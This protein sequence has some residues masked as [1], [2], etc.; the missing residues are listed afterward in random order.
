M[1]R[2]R[3]LRCCWRKGWWGIP[4]R[5]SSGHQIPG[6]AITAI[7]KRWWNFLP[8]SL[9]LC[10][11]LLGGCER[12]PA[13][14]A[15]PAAPTQPPKS[16]AAAQVERLL[17]AGRIRE[18]D[19]LVDE[20]APGQ[21]TPN[22]EFLRMAARV[23]LNAGHPAAALS[24]AE[25]A[26]ALQPR[27]TETKVVL[28]VALVRTGQAA[29]GEK[30]LSEMAGRF[31]RELN[32]Q[33]QLAEARVLAGKLPE[34]ERAA[35]EAVKLSPDDVGSAPAVAK[36][37]QTLGIVLIAQHRDPEA[38][39][40]LRAAIGFYP[41]SAG[42]HYSLSIALARAGKLDEARAAAAQA[43][44]LDPNNAEF[45][46]N[47]GTILLEQKQWTTAGAS[48][49]KAVALETGDARAW[50]ALGRALLQQKRAPEAAA[51]LEKAVQLDPTQKSA[52]SAL[53]SAAR[54]SGKSARAKEAEEK[55][56]SLPPE[57]AEP[58]KFLN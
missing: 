4:N 23:K 14:P 44:A 50:G 10:G 52:W 47:L 1:G 25:Q 5:S 55:A 27:D 24:F 9:V 54:L 20:Y 38:I 31:S 12:E 30:L 34:A 26:L 7:A 40:E 18:A 11:L 56:K 48:L 15:T 19:K 17:N 43:V 2:E 29:R 8:P 13:K 32:F 46:A 3:R 42:S 53:A 36:T 45:L 58:L 28:G 49:E 35:R 33:C 16:E 51:A 39:A 57:P 6:T 41:R 21:T 22:W 37:H